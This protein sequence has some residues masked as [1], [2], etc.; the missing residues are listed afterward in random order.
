MK[1]VIFIQSKL[2]NKEQA[3]L[4]LILRWNAYGELLRNQTT[5]ADIWIFTPKPLSIEARDQVKAT[6][7]RLFPSVEKGASFT[8][9]LRA[10]Y[11][12]ISKSQETVT[13]VCG[14]NQQSLLIALVAKI[15]IGDLIR[16]QIQFHGDTYTFRSAS[17]IQGLFR[18][19]LSRVGIHFADSI[20]I[21]SKFQADEII[22]FSPRSEIKLVLA[23][24]PVDFSRVARVSILNKFDIAF[25]GRLHSERGILELIA[26]LSKLLTEKPGIRVVIVGD[27]PLRKKIESDLAPWISDSTVS[28][29]GFLSGEEIR[30]IYA[31][32]RLLISTAPQEGYGL[33]L[34]EAALSRVRVIAHESK[35]VVE[36]Q[37]FFPAGIETYSSIDEAINLIRERLDE[38]REQLDTEMGPMQIESDLK[39]LNRLINSWQ[40]D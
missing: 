12:E 21:V 39:G 20:R 25:I 40:A 35:G 28:I 1:K 32:S 24:I 29:L 7:L 34:R 2:P 17:G 13:L 36:A 19:G 8:M 9:R 6:S 31:S 3:F 5:P 18:V 27:G 14:D 26:I 30:K 16:V 22:R 10:L 23:P 4:Q 15:L 37:E 38:P 33:T 11:R